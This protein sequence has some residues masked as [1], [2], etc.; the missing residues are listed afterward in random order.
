LRSAKKHFGFLAALFFCLLLCAGAATAKEYKF[1]VPV[2]K[3]FS[4]GSLATI[5]KNMEKAIEKSTGFKIN[6]IEYSYPYDEDPI[7]YVLDKMNNNEA[8]FAM[9][10]PMEYLMYMLT[11]KKTNAIPLFSLN[12]FGKPTYQACAYT[13]KSD[14]I[15]SLEQLRGKIWGGTRTRFGRYLL[16]SNNI[17]EPLNK[18]FKTL[19]FIPDENTAALFDALLSKKIDT[20]MVTDYQVKMIINTD[21]R[22]KEI[23]TLACADYDHNWIIAYRKGVPEEDANKLKNLFLNAEK[24]PDFAQFKF[25]L[26]AI[27]GKFVEVD[28]KNLRQTKKVAELIIKNGWF[29]EEMAFLKA[30]AK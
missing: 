1:I 9:I 3:N 16:Y 24:S 14:G 28:L 5:L 7:K 30:N 27:K 12:M 10:W 20:F 17:D 4:M 11:K 2:P 21:K 29:K 25:I 22:F 8:D 26:S 15:T 19:Q 23:V 18:F 6:V 13:R